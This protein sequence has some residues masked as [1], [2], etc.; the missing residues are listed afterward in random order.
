MPQSYSVQTIFFSDSITYVVKAY[1]TLMTILPKTALKLYYYR[2]N[3]FRTSTI[4]IDTHRETY[5]TLKPAYN[6]RQKTLGFA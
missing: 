6:L 5:L 2:H 1:L 3:G 4:G